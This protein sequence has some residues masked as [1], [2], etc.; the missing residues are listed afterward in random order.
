M[1]TLRRFL[2]RRPLPLLG[3]VVAGVL[4]V[5]LGGQALAATLA[6]QPTPPPTPGAAPAPAFN[7]YG[8]QQPN[9][10]G[11]G[12]GHRGGHGGLGHFFGGRFRDR[13]PVR[14][15]VTVPNGNNGYEQ[16]AFARGTVTAVSETSLSVKSADGTTTTFTLNGDTVYRSGRDQV[17]RTDIKLGAEVF[18]SGPHSG[19]ATTAR[20]VIIRPANAGQGGRPGATPTPSPTPTP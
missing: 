6:D 15:E 13:A 1:G 11:P 7:G 9:Q 18:A 17:A 14:G 3:W 2:T 20:H 12:R 5:A 10:A 16:L 4:A 19:S 8:Q